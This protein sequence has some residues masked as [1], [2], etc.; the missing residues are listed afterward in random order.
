MSDETR[1]PISCPVCREVIIGPL[2]AAV[3]LSDM[4]GLSMYGA[5]ARLTRELEERERTLPRTADGVPIV[6]GME[7]WREYLGDRWE[8]R[9]VAVHAAAIDIQYTSASSHAAQYA[10]AR[11]QYPGDW[12]AATPPAEGGGE[13]G[14]KDR[15]T[16]T[17]THQD[18]LQVDDGD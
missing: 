2:S 13:A 9:V 1:D 11:L 15:L 14:V 17:A 18:S 12:Y 10:V 4:H 8:A 5:L 7:L 16:T 3:H 6:P